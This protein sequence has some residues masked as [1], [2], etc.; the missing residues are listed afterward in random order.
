MLCTRIFHVVAQTQSDISHLFSSL[1]LFKYVSHMFSVSH[2]LAQYDYMFCEAGL[3]GYITRLY[4]GISPK[5][6]SHTIFHYASQ[7][8]STQATH[9][10][11]GRDHAVSPSLLGIAVT[12]EEAG[13]MSEIGEESQDMQE[14]ARISESDHVCN[15]E[16]ESK[17]DDGDKSVKGVWQ[18]RSWT[19]RGNMLHGR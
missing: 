15:I 11:I 13:E 19:I 8:L 7:H 3:A 18:I 16:D 4:K 14:N 10:P 1:L 17:H 12:R 2:V 9:G 5:Y 6:S